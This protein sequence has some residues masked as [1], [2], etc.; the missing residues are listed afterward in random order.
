MSVA[1]RMNKPLFDLFKIWYNNNY[2]HDNILCYDL[3]LYGPDLR[4]ILSIS[5]KYDEKL[6][7]FK[8]TEWFRQYN[9]IYYITP[10]PDI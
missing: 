3:Q 7:L 8:L 1:H 5:L 6:E 4:I 10:A 2:D 9:R